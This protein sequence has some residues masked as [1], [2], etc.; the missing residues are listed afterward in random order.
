MS[1]QEEISWS[2]YLMSRPVVVFEDMTQESMERLMREMFSAGFKASNDA[3]ERAV[4]PLVS[5]TK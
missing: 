5:P 3:W 4:Q 1:N 2:K